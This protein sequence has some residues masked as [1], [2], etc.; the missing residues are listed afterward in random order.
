VIQGQLDIALDELGR[1]QAVAAARVLA[2]LRPDVLV[3]SDLSRAR[4]TAEVLAAA[5][6]L[7]VTFDP[8]LRELDL[9]SWQGLTSEQAREQHP[10]EHAA[11]LDG[12]DVPRGG[13]ETYAQAGARAAEAVLS[14]ALPPDGTLVAVTHGGTARAAVAALLEL[15]DEHAWRVAALGNCCWSV[16]VQARRGWR[17]EQHG[18]GAVAVLGSG[19]ELGGP[20]P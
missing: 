17:L 11:W 16:L 3:S 1:A 10:D 14:L 15:P 12:V 20:R 2:A 5:C 9:G 6:D 18:V 4:E 13:G 7:P 8:R 19:P